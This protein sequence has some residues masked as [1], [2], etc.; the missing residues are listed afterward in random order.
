[1]ESAGAICHVTVD[2]KKME[3]IGCWNRRVGG[4]LS[5]R[6]R[7]Q[8]VCRSREYGDH[9]RRGSGMGR[10]SVLPVT[11]SVPAYLDLASS[12]GGLGLL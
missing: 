7:N 3:V 5:P 6:R 11:R 4:S 12:E 1:M 10:A 8:R 2:C 9:I